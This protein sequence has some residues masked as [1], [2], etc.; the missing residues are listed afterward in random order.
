MR[1]VVVAALAVGLGGAAVAGAL[2]A[3]RA[4]AAELSAPEIV[5]RNAAARGGLD[6]WRK[7]GT[8]V[9]IGHIDSAHAPVPDLD[10]ALEQ[11]RPNK[12]RLE[13]HTP[14]QGSVR[15]FDGVHGW[16][17]R[18][19]P[20]RPAVEP[21]SPEELRFARTGHG[22][23]GPLLDCVAKG[24]VVTVASL[25][26]IAGRKAYHLKVQPAAGAAEELWID[27]ETFLEV[28]LD[29]M[30]EGPAGAPRRV[31]VTY[32]DY[33]TVEGLRLP[34]LIETG[35]GGP[36]ADKMRIDRVTLNAPLDDSNFES[37]TV[38]SRRD[39]ARPP[40][41]PR[42]PDPDAPATASIRPRGVAGP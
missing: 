28:R 6:A 3:A 40:A 1:R 12:T 20:G 9:W 17:A 37:P 26:E 30:T 2:A 21:Y 38:A 4:P 39:R 41:A 15:I 42:A 23:D 8:M 24:S 5:A 13:I 36:T 34:F 22:I 10:F 16:K 14:G 33:R 19:A 32:G 25:D 27:A 11:K 7:I 35:N 31:S 29:R 18:P